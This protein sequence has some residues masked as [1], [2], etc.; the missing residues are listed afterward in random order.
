MVLEN[1][2]LCSVCFSFYTVRHLIFSGEN[3]AT[4]HMFTPKSKY[5]QR[6]ITVE[7]FKC[8][9]KGCVHHI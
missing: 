4:T 9:S 5:I 2:M 8:I 6:V 3:M 7:C 1:L